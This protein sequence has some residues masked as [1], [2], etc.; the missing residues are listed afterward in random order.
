MVRTLRCFE[1]V[2][3]RR[4]RSRRRTMKVVK[5]RRRQVG[6]VPRGN[7]DMVVGEKTEKRRPRID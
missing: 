7:F 4:G 3:V 6:R 5:R 2:V 1:K